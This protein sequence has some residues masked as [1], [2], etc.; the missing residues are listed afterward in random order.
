MSGHVWAGN[1]PVQVADAGQYELGTVLAALED[2]TVDGLRIFSTTGAVDLAGRTGHLWGMDGTTLATVSLPTTLPAGWS[3][4]RF[5]APVSLD[6]GGLAVVS[7]GSGGNYSTVSGAFTAGPVV[8]QDG[9]VAFPA[10]A[11]TKDGNGRFIASPGTFP[12]ATFAGTFYSA[13]VL[14]T[15]L[16]FTATPPA[17]VYRANTDLVAVAWLS[18]V[19]GVPSDAVATTLPADNSTWAASGFVQV[20]SGVGSSVNPDVPLRG[21]VVQV[22]C[23][24]VNPDSAKPPWG[25]ANNLAETVWSACYQPTDVPRLLTLRSGYPQARVLSLWPVSEIRRLPG[26]DISSYAAYTFDLAVRWVELPT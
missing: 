14:Y 8:A 7:Y 22:T 11:A 5:T 4:H 3:E 17:A 2:V 21:P 25:K 1:T 18:G 19:D 9:A 20:T 23:W 12:D 26:G 15:P 24:A 16:G 13:D 6:A 10:T